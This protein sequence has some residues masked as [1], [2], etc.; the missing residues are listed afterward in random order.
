[1]SV[2]NA[3]LAL[4]GQGPKYGYQLRAEFEERT[5]GSWPLNIGQVYTTLN[6]LER[7]GLVKAMTEVPVPG[8]EAATSQVIYRVTESGQA[9]IDAW[10]ASPVDRNAPPRDELA[11][12]IAL[13]V[14]LPG[15]DVPGLVQQ[16]RSATMRSLQDF[17]RL[18]R[19]AGED[20]LAWGLVLDRLIFDAEAEVRWLDHCEA[21]VRRAAL[22]RVQTDGFAAQV[23]Q[24]SNDRD[25]EVGR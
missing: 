13:A 23:Q 16:Q 20:D 7:D 24:T 2:K 3:L 1:M 17:T 21:R 5:G 12:K 9:A 8:A 19:Q 25:Q 22:Q 4:V 15:V 10:F 14:T 11:I 6:R 18:K